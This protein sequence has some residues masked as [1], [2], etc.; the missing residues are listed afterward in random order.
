MSNKRNNK[1]KEKFFNKEQKQ[2]RAGGTNFTILDPFE[3]N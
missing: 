2:E 1:Q 3:Q